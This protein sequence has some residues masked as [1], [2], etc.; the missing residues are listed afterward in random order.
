MKLCHYERSEAIY[1]NLSGLPRR[2]I[3]LLAMT[4]NLRLN[5]KNG[6]YLHTKAS[7]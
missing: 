6:I 1:L 7:G 5:L 2:P 3:G 4:F